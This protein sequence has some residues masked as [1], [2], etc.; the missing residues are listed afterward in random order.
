MSIKDSLTPKDTEEL[1]P[2]FFVQKQ[3][4]KYR[5]VQPIIWKGKWRLKNQIEWRDIFFIALII[6]LFFGGQNYVRFYE[7]TITDPAAFCA[8]NNITSIDVGQIKWEVTDEN[9]FDLSLDTGVY[10]G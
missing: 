10:S 7:E 9:T 4:N 5:Q 6:G 8:L 1:K 2:G 3:G